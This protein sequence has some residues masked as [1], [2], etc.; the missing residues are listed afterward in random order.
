MII[1][2]LQ[3]KIVTFIESVAVANIKIKMKERFSVYLLKKKMGLVWILK[4]VVIVNIPLS[5]V[6]NFSTNNNSGE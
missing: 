5:L 1:Q 3:R 2:P 6:V 4:F